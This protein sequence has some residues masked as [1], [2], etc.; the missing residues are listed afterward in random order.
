MTPRARLLLLTAADLLMVG[1]GI[2]AA[3]LGPAFSVAFLGLV[4]WFL[5]AAW[6]RSPRAPVEPQTRTGPILTGPW[7]VAPPGARLPDQR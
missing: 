6:F 7:S 1:S 4:L 2:G 3:F 5:G